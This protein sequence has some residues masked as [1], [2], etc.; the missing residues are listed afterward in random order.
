M[1][2]W[3]LSAHDPNY[4]G[5]SFSEFAVMADSVTETAFGP[6]VRPTSDL[7]ALD[8]LRSFGDW[9]EHEHQI[10]DA[11]KVESSAALELLYGDWRRTLNE[12]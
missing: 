5:E 6:L 2:L 3:Y 7:S 9:L 8:A 10:T 11:R 1:A 4:L 12:E